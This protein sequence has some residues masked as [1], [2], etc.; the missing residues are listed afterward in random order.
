MN[1]DQ[2]H[3]GTNS[4]ALGNFEVNRHGIFLS[5]NPDFAKAYGNNVH[6]LYANIT[7]P[8][9]I[10]PDL[11]EDFIETI[12]PFGEERELWIWARYA[13]N[14]WQYFDNQLG[15]RFVEWLKSQGYDGAVFDDYTR[16]G[17]DEFEGKTYVA[18]NH[19]QLARQPF[20]EKK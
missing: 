16:D 6:E 14:D 5:D 8:A 19:S 13:P 1:L 3:V 15:E 4:S 12:D 17:D 9:V 10:T 2:T 18:F 7:N 20:S 11:K